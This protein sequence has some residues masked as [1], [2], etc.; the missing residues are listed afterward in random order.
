MLTLKH[1]RKRECVESYLFSS[2]VSKCQGKRL[3]AHVVLSCKPSI[4]RLSQRIWASLG[5]NG[6]E[7]KERRE[8]KRGWWVNVRLLYTSGKPKSKP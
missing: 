3:K 5:Y 2:K 4:K 8:R 7:V 1:L 6:E